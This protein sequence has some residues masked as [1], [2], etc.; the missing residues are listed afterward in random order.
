MFVALERLREYKIL[1]TLY[2]L[3]PFHNLRNIKRVP[4]AEVLRNKNRL[5]IV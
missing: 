3:V 2:I 5:L 4:R 1:S